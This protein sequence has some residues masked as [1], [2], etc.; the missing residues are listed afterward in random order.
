MGRMDLDWSIGCYETTASQLEPVA[1]HVVHVAQ[2]S[3]TDDVLD[4]GCGTGNAALLAAER[5]ARVTAIDPARRLL[6]TA[7]QRAAAEQRV[8]RFVTGTAA[9]IPAPA[10]SFDV[11]VAVFSVI[12]AP[13]P[14]AA[15]AEM[16]RVLRP[17]GR[18]VVTSW[19]PHGTIHDLLVPLLPAD[20]PPPTSPWHHPA[21]IERLFEPLHASTSIEQ[22]ALP[23]EAASADAYFDDLELNHPFWL[24][25]RSTRRA[26]WDSVRQAS[27]EILRRGNELKE[28]FRATCEYLVTLARK[29]RA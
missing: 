16:W 15:V 23:I 10:E 18:L 27:V 4:V 19:R 26:D 14:T 1:R 5:G 6:E 22:K 29:P 21:T 13:D 17:G 28:G 9:E 20:V 7:A 12:F 3:P 24:Q 25:Y 2:V 8:I 11:V